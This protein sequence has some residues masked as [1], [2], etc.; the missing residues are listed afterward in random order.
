MLLLTACMPGQSA[1]RRASHGGHQQAP[2]PA[3]RDRVDAH[4]PHAALAQRRRSRLDIG[5]VDVRRGAWVEDRGHC[6]REVLQRNPHHVILERGQLFVVVGDE[7]CGLVAAGCVR[8][9]GAPAAEGGRPVRER[10]AA[11]VERPSGV[12]CLATTLQL[13]VCHQHRPLWGQ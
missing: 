11:L 3:S 1:L 7:D 5:R 6:L 8:G 2:R 4:V 10:L 13:A 12:V 9:A